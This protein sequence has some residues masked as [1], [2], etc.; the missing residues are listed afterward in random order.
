VFNVSRDFVRSMSTPLLILCGSDEYH[1][2]PTSQE[3]AKLAP[4][5][6]IIVSWKTPD[7]IRD[8]IRRVREFLITHRP[9]GASEQSS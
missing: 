1:P 6:E 8:T 5:A 4:N 2:T 3:I 9:R 7:V